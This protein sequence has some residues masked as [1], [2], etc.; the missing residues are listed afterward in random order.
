[1]VVHVWRTGAA[2]NEARCEYFGVWIGDVSEGNQ[3]A[4]RLRVGLGLG[5][6]FRQPE[7]SRMDQVD[8]HLQ[9]VRSMVSKAVWM[10]AWEGG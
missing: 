8:A 7:R 1:M 10:H 2:D 4:V 6:S 3:S 5:M 9:S